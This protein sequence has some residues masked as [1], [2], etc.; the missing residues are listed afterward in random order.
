[1][2]L[3]SFGFLSVGTAPPTYTFCKQQVW[4]WACME[5]SDKKEGGRVEEERAGDRAP[6]R[7]TASLSRHTRPRPPA[8][9]R[10]HTRPPTPATGTTWVRPTGCWRPIWTRW[11]G[12]RLASS[13]A[14]SRQAT[15]R[16]RSSSVTEPSPTPPFD[17]GWCALPLPAPAV[18]A[19]APPAAVVGRP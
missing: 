19:S 18:P 7:E 6:G 1:M 15:S 14:R 17:T 16:A 13:S 3:P 5:K 8:P 12:G 11:T 10:A 2:S 4:I 9:A